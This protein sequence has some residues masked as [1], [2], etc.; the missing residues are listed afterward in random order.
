MNKKKEF[1][2]KQARF[3]TQVAPLCTEIAKHF[4]ENQSVLIEKA[5]FGKF[6]LIEKDVKRVPDGVL[7]VRFSSDSGTLLSIK[8]TKKNEGGDCC[9]NIRIIGKSGKEVG[10]HEEGFKQT[11]KSLHGSLIPKPQKTPPPR[12]I[13]WCF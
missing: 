9:S 8:I 12:K 6:E 1:Q 2:Q 3:N 5:R 7:F 4:W 10:T 11:I 13:P